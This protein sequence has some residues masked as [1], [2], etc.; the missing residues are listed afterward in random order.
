M[1]QGRTKLGL[2]C[3]QGLVSFF[4]ATAQSGGLCVIPGSHQSHTKF[5]GYA[6]TNASDFVPVPR[7]DPVLCAPRKLVTC[8]AG[9]L[10]LWDSRT[11]HCNTPAVDVPTSP[12]DEPLRLVAYVCMTPAAKA[13]AATRIR[14]CNA[15]AT[16][17][18]TSHWPHEFHPN[19][20]T[21]AES[22]PATHITAAARGQLELFGGARQRLVGFPR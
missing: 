12:P 8:E 6:A 10:L 15:A 5:L 16:G 13:T 17:V 4:P 21:A 14:R 7:G 20:R 3:V 9:D 1:P 2:Q 22:T 19:T 18:T 11:L